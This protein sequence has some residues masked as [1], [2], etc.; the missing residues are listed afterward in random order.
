MKKRLFVSIPLSTEDQKTLAAAQDRNQFRS[1]RWV[2]PAQFHLTVCFLGDTDEALLPYISDALSDCVKEQKTFSLRLQRIGVFPPKLARPNML[3]A[4]F[5]ENEAF[6]ALVK[7]VKQALMKADAGFMRLA[8]E[9][10]K[11]IPHVTLA[12]FKG[13]EYPRQ[14]P[15]APTMNL[16]VREVELMESV[17]YP[18]GP[19]Y[20]TLETF[21]FRS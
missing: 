4:F 2:D 15:Q 12:R 8:E 7:S 17:L 21:P 19:V 14:A 18:D 10:R 3:W 16:D 6:E 9:W 11:D 13:G 1:L 20:S 5:E